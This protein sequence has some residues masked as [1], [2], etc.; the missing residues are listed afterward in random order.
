MSGSQAARPLRV[1]IVGL[2]PK[3]LF[4]LERL[5]HHSRGLPAGSI[6]LTIYE[7]HPA[8]GAGPVYDPAQPPYLRMNFAAELVDMWLERPRVLPSLSGA[9]MRR[10]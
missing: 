4:A 6:E 2:G 9:A 5:V 7:P 3:G 10:T 1:A 8:P